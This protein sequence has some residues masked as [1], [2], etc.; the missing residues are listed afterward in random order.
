MTLT[1]ARKAAWKVQGVG[2]DPAHPLVVFK[3]IGGGKVFERILKPGEVLKRPWFSSDETY[4]AY[5]VSTDNHLRHSFSRKYQTVGQIRTFTLHF[6]LHFRVQDARQ[7]ALR[8]ED[9]DPLQRLEDEVASV[10]SATARH[11]SW[12]LL[13]IEGPDFG[14]RLLEAESSDGDGERKGNL[15]RLRDFAND[16][17]L[18][19][20]NVQL[21]RSLPDDEIIPDKFGKNEIEQLAIDRIRH[22]ADLERVQMKQEKD[23]LMLQGS[24]ALRGLERVRMVLD[25]ISKEGVRGF[26]QAVNGI[27]S[28]AAINDALVE[29]QGIQTSLFALSSGQNLSRALGSAGEPSGRE[30][31]PPAASSSADPMERLVTRA[32]HHLRTLDG[33][34]ADRRQILTLV[35][36]LVA[37]AGMEPKGDEEFLEGCLEQLAETLYPLK[38]ALEPDLREF[39]EHLSDIESLRRELARESP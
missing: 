21:T 10:L 29:I 4:E 36:H 8:L 35:L 17:G 18:E 28:F 1:E 16:L 15:D 39:L 37:E 9:G 19:L 22:A 6:E 13:K 3:K 26:S 31:L 12:E 2:P 7:L 30:A 33:N 11:F 5:A 14:L 20:R 32:F 23:L 25:E 27:R 34:S 38:S 24:N